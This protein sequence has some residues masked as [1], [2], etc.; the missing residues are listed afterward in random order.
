MNKP[1]N[2][3]DNA[4]IQKILESGGNP[5]I[6]EKHTYLHWLS[7]TRSLNSNPKL[8]T[9]TNLLIENSKG[10]SVIHTAAAAGSLE[11][12][13]RE[14]LSP[15]TLLAI[16]YAGE[17]SYHAAARSGVNHLKQIPKALLTPE[18]LQIKNDF[19]ENCYHL[20]AGRGE[21]KEL[22]SFTGKI[23]TTSELLQETLEGKNCFHIAIGKNQFNEYLL[24]K[25]S[26]EAVLATD[27]QGENILHL[28]AKDGR[29]NHLPEKLVDKEGLWQKDKYG[30]TP[31]AVAASYGFIKEIKE[32]HITK[33]VLL[34]KDT[35]NRCVFDHLK[36]N[37]TSRFLRM[38]S[39]C[40]L[41]ILQKNKTIKKETIEKE[42][43]KRK[44]KMEI[45]HNSCQES[46]VIDH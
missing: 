26:K 36:A 24:S 43:S 45:F 17:N 3:I 18:F 35:L 8:L 32:K 39:D 12:I 29:I 20:L 19:G 4:E 46:V 1:T 38:F 14:F 9:K 23:L 16:D 6:N 7:S 21:L 37:E 15:E 30:R 33:E 31:I 34:L 44:L 11:Q 13:P 10:Q 42:L 28:L 5:Y 25:L 41:E 22:E 40:E 27:K 2:K